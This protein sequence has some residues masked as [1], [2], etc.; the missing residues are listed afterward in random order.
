MLYGLWRIEKT[1]DDA[2]TKFL[3]SIDTNIE[4]TLGHE[5][6]KE[7]RA[8]GAGRQ[9]VNA[10]TGTR[11]FQSCVTFFDDLWRSHFR[12]GNIRARP[13]QTV[14]GGGSSA[15]ADANV[16]DDD[17]AFIVGGGRRP[18]IDRGKMSS[19]TNCWNCRGFGHTSEACPSEKGFR[20]ISDAA[21]LLTNMI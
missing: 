12:S 6:K 2:T 17:E 13:K 1:E 7:L 8:S 14:G 9:F 20:A 3:S 5:A 11:D 21:H 16:V 15:R 19:E 10:A 18:G 4:A